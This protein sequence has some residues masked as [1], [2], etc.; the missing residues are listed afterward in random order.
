MRCTSAISM[1]VLLPSALG[2]CGAG[3]HRLEDLTPRALPVRQQV[4]L[5]QGRHNRV[6]HAVTVRD[7]SVGGVPFHL[8]PDCDSCRVVIA[9]SLVDSMR[10]GNQERGALRSL[11][12][13][14]VAIGVAGL[15]L[16]L[17]VDTD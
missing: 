16:Y 14:Y 11:G 10:L 2:G 3:W 15:L 13:G 8:P 5:W 17:S 7:D 9:R 12:L 6:L 1:A 4:Q